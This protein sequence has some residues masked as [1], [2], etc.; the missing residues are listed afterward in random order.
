[1]P[2]L[3]CFCRPQKSCCS[4]IP[5]NPSLLAAPPIDR[6]PAGSRNPP[7]FSSPA[8]CHFDGRSQLCARGRAGVSAHRVRASESNEVGS[9]YN[10][11]YYWSLDLGE[12]ENREVRGRGKKSVVRIRT[13]VPLSCG[14]TGES[15]GWMHTISFTR[16][17]EIRNNN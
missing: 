3:P 12:S 14:E 4:S 16:E 7:L 9:P 10:I 11:E 15:I 13:P 5:C 8:A 17:P 6:P 2:L 1:M